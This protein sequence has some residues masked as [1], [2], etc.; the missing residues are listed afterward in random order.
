MPQSRLINWV[1]SAP[2]ALHGEADRRQ[3]APLAARLERLQLAHDAIPDI[4]VG[5]EFRGELDAL[6]DAGRL[7]QRAGL[8]FGPGNLISDP[9]TVSRQARDRWPHR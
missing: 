6:L 4:A 3:E 2:S 7:G 1:S 9:E 5:H 8:S